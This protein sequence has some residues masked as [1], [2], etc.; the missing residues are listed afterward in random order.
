VSTD[1]LAGLFTTALSA[2]GGL[3]TVVSAEGLADAVADIVGPE[4]I[5]LVDPELGSLAEELRV[6]GIDARS[7]SS[8]GSESDAALFPA[9]AAAAE[10]ADT[11]SRATCGIT[12]A[13][14]GIAASGT[15]AIDTRS[16]NAGLLSCLPPHHIAVLLER[17][18]EPTLTDALETLAQESSAS[19]AGFVLT[20]G[21]SRTSDIEMMSVLGVHGPLRLD[22]VLIREDA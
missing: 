14:L 8:R 7:G 20:T 18:I 11:A 1:D 9:P 19:G 4:G 17:S 10:F 22:V 13:L 3:S 12:G 5:V 15:V 6:R 21:P 2:C 16:G